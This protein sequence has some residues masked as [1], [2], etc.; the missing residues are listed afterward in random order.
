MGQIISKKLWVSII[1]IAISLF[2][3][4]YVFAEVSVSVPEN[5]HNVVSPFEH[6]FRFIVSLKN[7]GIGP[8]TISFGSDSKTNADMKNWIIIFPSGRIYL[9]PGEEREIIAT[10]EPMFNNKSQDSIDYDYVFNVN[11]GKKTIP[12]KIETRKLDVGSLEMSPVNITVLDKNTGEKIIGAEYYL[13]LPSGM[14]GFHNV[15][16]Y[17]KTNPIEG[18]KTSIIEKYILDN[19]VQLSFSGYF[20]RIEKEGYKPAYLTNVKTDSKPQTIYLEPQTKYWEYKEIKQAKT[21]FSFWWVKPSADNKLFATSPG[22]HAA[23]G[24]NKI[25]DEVGIYLFNDKG[26]KLWRYPIKSAGYDG[27]DLCW[28]LDISPD[29]NYVAAGCYDGN[30]YLLNKKGELIKKYQGGNMVTVVAFSPDNKYLAF[31]PAEGNK[32]VG[33]VDVAT[34]EYVWTATLGDRARTLSFSPDSK[35]LAAGSPNGIVTMFD[36]FGKRV[37]RDSNGG[38]VP[39]LSNFS[40]DGKMFIISGKGREVIAYEPLTGKKLWSKIVD[41]T[42]WP[43]INNVSFDG[44]LAFGTVGGQLWYFNKDGNPLWRYEYGN[45]GHNGA[46]LT[47]NGEYFLVGGGNPTLFDKNGTILWEMDP[48]IERD[49]LMRIPKESIVGAEVVWLS[50][51]A[52]KMVLGMSDGTIKFLEGKRNDNNQI[53][54]ENI[55]SDKFNILKYLIWTISFFVMII[56]IIKLI[57]NKKSNQ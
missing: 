18:I 36:I 51:D 14:D 3:I 6:N 42:P 34:A 12:I 27:S 54:E 46:F 49:K 9:E 55:L 10:L 56:F 44:Q 20:L 39:F 22:I 23:P 41:Q 1:I 33:V 28:G 4:P 2:F 17:S 40:G 37:W 35:L 19:N 5:I 15:L 24:E 7:T 50:E 32:D 30:V 48:S 8:A 57:N 11:A 52:S 47:K 26:E 16:D 43:G 13:S 25:P 21:E 45:F 31:G 38:L 29:G 53:V